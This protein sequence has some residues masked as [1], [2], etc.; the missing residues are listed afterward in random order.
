MNN[1]AG[2]LIVLAGLFLYLAMRDDVRKSARETWGSIG[3]FVWCMVVAVAFLA[4]LLILQGLLLA[5]IGA[6]V[7]EGLK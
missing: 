1:D 2:G 7:K 6:V 3:R 4:V 5:G